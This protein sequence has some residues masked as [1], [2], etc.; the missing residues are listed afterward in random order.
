MVRLLILGAF[1]L[2]Y[3]LVKWIRELFSPPTKSYND[4]QQERRDKW[5]IRREEERKRNEI[6][7]KNQQEIDNGEV[8]RLWPKHAD[9]VATFLEIAERKVSVLDDY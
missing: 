1:Y 4:L 6:E 7:K 9:L 3:L 2:L 5:R 8:E